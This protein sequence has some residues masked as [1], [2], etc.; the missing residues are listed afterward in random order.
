MRRVVPRYIYIYV[1]APKHL[2][3]ISKRGLQITARRYIGDDD[4]DDDDDALEDDN[5][6]KMMMRGD[7]G[8]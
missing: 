5:D 8:E 7:D 1:N 4:D 3:H 2:Y 6:G